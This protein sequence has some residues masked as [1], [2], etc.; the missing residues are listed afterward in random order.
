MAGDE[1]SPLEAP[2]K[3]I[4]DAAK[5]LIAAFG[6]IGA[7]LV[8]G[9]SLSALPSGTH[10]LLAAVAVA[11]AVL[12]LALMIGLGVSVLTPE[13]I[14]LGGLA[15]FERSGKR[16][17]VVNRLKADEALFQG[18]PPDLDSFHQT[19]V[20]ALRDRAQKQEEYLQG[21]DDS[22]RQ[23]SEVAAARA[24]F[25]NEAASQLLDTAVYYQLQDKFSPRRRTIM[26]LL[27]LVVVAAA[28]TFAWAAA[29]STP[30]ADQQRSPQAE[31]IWLDH[32]IATSGFRIERLQQ[33][34]ENATNADAVD[35]IDRA[36]ALQR[37]AQRQEREALRDLS[38]EAS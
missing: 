6:A 22:R 27:A 9:L 11:V 28:G 19:Y 36:L 2:A 37:R 24:E 31:V 35:R 1:G 18:Q 32:L 25:L 4:R 10:P 21:P 7:V 33:E 29:G 3:A 14:T 8:G 30:S 17:W 5:Y 12:S 13:A 16:S 15:E 23:A 38:K 34:G 26:I 20:Q